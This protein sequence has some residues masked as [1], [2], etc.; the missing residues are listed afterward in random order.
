MLAKANEA[1]GESVDHEKSDFS[2]LSDDELWALEALIAKA[3]GRPAYKPELLLPGT[4]AR[5][6]KG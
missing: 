5:I 1:N 6:A 2:V 3:T 4:L